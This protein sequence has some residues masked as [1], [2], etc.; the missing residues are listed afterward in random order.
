[1]DKKKRV[2]HEQRKDKRFHL[3]EGAFVIP[4]AR[5]RKLWQIMD[6]SQG[7]LAFQYVANGERVYDSSDLD[8]AYS[9]ASFYLEKVPFKAVS[10]LKVENGIRWSSLKLRRCGIQFGELTRN[11][12]SLLKEFIQN[13][14]R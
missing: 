11:Q 8:I 7:G 4:R 10:D 13:Q 14:A 1:M 2:E 6:I 5:S 3:K 9:G 12:A